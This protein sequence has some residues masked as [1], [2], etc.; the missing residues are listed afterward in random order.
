MPRR[1]RAAS[2]WPAV[3]FLAFFAVL[4]VFV[5]HYYLLPAMEAKQ[6]AT[7]PA[8]SLLRAQAA[9]LLSLLLVMLLCG[10]V[11]TFKVHRFFLPRKWTPGVRTKYVDAWAEA[12]KRAE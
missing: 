3:C 11:L 1:P 5:S 9:L 6:A 10:L 4:I 2:P 7:Q 8:Q 12:G